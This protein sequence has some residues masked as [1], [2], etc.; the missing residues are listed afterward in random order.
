[1]PKGVSGMV[2]VRKP[3]ILWLLGEAKVFEREV[4]ALL[5]TVED[6]GICVAPT[7]STAPNQVVR[8]LKYKEQD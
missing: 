6:R 2:Y 8:I 7:I 3:E 1:M 4:L 5:L